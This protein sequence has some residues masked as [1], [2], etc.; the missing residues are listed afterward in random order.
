MNNENQIVLSVRLMTYNHERY[1]VKTLEGI[2]KQKTNFYF[3]AV[4]G[5]DFSTDN[6]L[7]II[8]TYKFNNDNL[9]VNILDRNRGDEYDLMRQ[10]RG[11]LYNFTNIIKN[12]RGKY[13]AL[14]DGDDYWTDPLKL[15]KQIDFLEHNLDYSMCFHPVD[16]LRNG[17]IEADNIS[18]NIAETTTILDLAKRNYMHTCSVVFRN[19]LFATFPKYFNTAPVGDYFLHL[20][21]ARYGKIK[22]ITKKMGVYRLHN[23]SM[24]SSKPQEEQDLL[25]VSFL[26]NIKPNFNREV[27]RVIDNQINLIIRP[28]IQAKES[29]IERKI[30]TKIVKKIKQFF[31]PK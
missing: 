7:K 15:Q 2:N 4:V 21:N 6:T 17:I 14:L 29:S 20:L 11:R 16:I 10:K 22:C 23:R 12:C 18:E 19:N 5:D 27:R 28:Q 25:W 8:K 30:K 26:K 31:K 3:E 24:W 1:I 9:I 13:I